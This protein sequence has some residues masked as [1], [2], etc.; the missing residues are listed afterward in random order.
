MLST[1]F[2]FKA[3]MILNCSMIVFSC[4]H[5]TSSGN[6]TK[7]TDTTAVKVT[8]PATGSA[9]AEVI[10]S[11]PKT[12]QLNDM[13]RLIAGLPVDSTSKYYKYTQMPAWKKYEADS[14][15]LWDKFGTM[16]AKITEWKNKEIP[17]VNDT[18]QTLYY[19][20]SGPD[21]LFAN[22]FFPN[23]K[24][25]ILLGL[26]SPGNVPVLKVSNND[27]LK[28]LLDLYKVAIEDVVQL[29]F[30]RTN[31][32]KVDL[33]SQVID[34]T[35]PILM[36]FLARSGKEI[37]DV[38]PMKLTM[39][40]KLTPFETDSTEKADAVEVSFRNPKEN[41]MRR[42][43]YLST[44]VADPTLSKNTP[45]MKFF[46][47]LDSGNYTFIKSATYLMHKKYFS[48]IRNS[49]LNKSKVILQDASGIA[50]KFYDPAKWD[51]SLY[52]TYE[53]PIDLFKDFYE[54]DLEAAFQ[55]SSK[56][57]GFRY[58]YNKKSSLLFAKLK[59]H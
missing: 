16:A 18:I 51:I 36:L 50:F 59:T 34:G 14:K 20:F 55:K 58:G 15:A 46:D 11:T 44:N 48:I 28:K 29:S 24:N 40:G 56:P 33:N 42:I 26:E 17:A 41:I 12:I 13:A 10:E 21:Y 19:P 7:A 4:N 6:E 27:D 49:V 57:I 38:T 23:A 54:P 2:C 47:N 1:R 39:Q 53:K 43:I 45:F 37:L 5:T 52:G 9:D 25:Y 22:L 35:A 8:I 30:F 31:D 3:L 32:M